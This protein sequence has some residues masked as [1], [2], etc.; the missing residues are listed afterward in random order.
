M[1]YQERDPYLRDPNIRR[2]AS[3]Q[4]VFAGALGAGLG[5]AIGGWVSL[6]LAAP[7][8]PRAVVGGGALRLGSRLGLAGPRRPG[9]RASADRYRR[10]A[11][12]AALSPG[13]DR[14]GLDDPRGP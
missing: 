1:A 13:A 5:W 4:I 6:S 3:L 2:A 14:A 12:R 7:P 10:H 9:H 8:P 11:R